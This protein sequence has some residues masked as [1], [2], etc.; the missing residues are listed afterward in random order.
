MI[1]ADNRGTE[2]REVETF[3]FIERKVEQ[4]GREMS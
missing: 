1:D 4:E 3:L 2:L